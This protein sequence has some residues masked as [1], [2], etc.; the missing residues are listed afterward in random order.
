VTFKID[1]Q[2]AAV[3]GY[4]STLSRVC[5]RGMM[6]PLGRLDCEYALLPA[7]APERLRLKLMRGKPPLKSAAKKRQRA[8]GAPAGAAQARAEPRLAAQLAA[9]ADG[10]GS[11]RYVR[12]CAWCSAANGAHAPAAAARTRTTRRRA[13]GELACEVVGRAAGADAARR[14]RESDEDSDDDGDGDGGDLLEEDELLSEEDLGEVSDEAGEGDGDEDLADEDKLARMTAR[15]R[16]LQT[17]KSS[18]FLMSIPN[19][20]GEQL[21]RSRVLWRGRVPTLRRG[22][23]RG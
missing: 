22:C 4:V 2:A 18:E 1:G 12:C 19:G 21:R 15:Q 8:A 11:A 6:A 17:G 20:A 9:A 14:L 5:A 7:R 3:C 13:M 23:R 10:N 16:A